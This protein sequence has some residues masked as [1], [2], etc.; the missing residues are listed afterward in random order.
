MASV[1][2]FLQDWGNWDAAGP[3]PPISLAGGTPYHL[4]GTLHLHANPLSGKTD[5]L[6]NEFARSLTPPEPGFPA[7]V[8]Q[9]LAHFTSPF[10]RRML[11]T[12]LPYQVEEAAV[13]EILHLAPS[14]PPGAPAKVAA[15][16]LTRYSLALQDWTQHPAVAPVGSCKHCSPRRSPNPAP[17]AADV[18][19]PSLR[20]LLGQDRRS[21]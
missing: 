8:L 7:A 4:E 16:L 11:S 3:K 5:L 17:L 19:L 14:F 20:S 13:T 12:P 6:V 1:A 21:A 18:L 2:G 10:T 15:Q 9:C